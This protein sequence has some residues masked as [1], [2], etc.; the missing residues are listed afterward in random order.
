MDNYSAVIISG[1]ITGE[2]ARKKSYE[3]EKNDSIQTN[4]INLGY[5]QF[6]DNLKYVGILVQFLFVLFTFSYF[7]KKYFKKNKNEGA[8]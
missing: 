2:I 3:R 5:N 1:I 8:K 7:I 6:Q 4:S